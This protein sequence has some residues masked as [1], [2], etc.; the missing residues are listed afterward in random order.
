MPSINTNIAAL[1]AHQGLLR[2]NADLS[3]RL[4]RLSTGLRL[5]RAS[6][7]PAGQIKADRLGMELSGLRAAIDSAERGSALIGALDGQLAAIAD[8]LEALKALVGEQGDGA[9]LPP[10]DRQLAIDAELQ[11][12]E[13]IAN[14]AVFGG[15]RLLD[16]SL[17][18][19]L[20]FYDRAMV[21]RMEVHQADLAP[22][23][24]S[25]TLD[26]LVAAE[27]GLL[28]APLNAGSFIAG[29]LSEDVTLEISGPKGVRTLTFQAGATPVD[30]TTAINQLRD[31]TGVQ[32]S[33]V[34]PSGVASLEFRTIEYGSAQTVTVRAVSGTGAQWATR[35]QIGGV[36]V[37]SDNGV[38]VG[39]LVNGIAWVGRGRQVHFSSAAV[40]FTATLSEPFATNTATAAQTI[41]VLG[42]GVA[43]QVGPGSTSN[44]RVSFGVSAMI[45]SQMGRAM[46]VLRSEFVLSQLASGEPMSI[47]GGGD[48]TDAMRI[49][50]AAI[51]EV[52]TTRARLGAID[53]TRLQG[54]IESLQSAVESA[55]AGRSAIRDADVAEE[56]SALV[57]AQILSEASISMIGVAN[58][59]A[60]ALLRLLNR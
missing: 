1:I 34:N 36:A 17:D 56:T 45:P 4:E 2:A 7:D 24:L 18:Y 39:G 26:V 12:I 52:S 48:P 54:A 23:S 10:G 57:R 16:G 13:A 29:V 9:A 46:G 21:A 20:S 25:I 19:D 27:Q 14:S 58:Q 28:Y 22:G 35:A 3:V 8:R 44:D 15:R 42:G 53:R 60:E 31:Q 47:A 38:D 40:S 59:N 30:M 55:T 37:D 11:G 43:Y 41:Q 6:D 32:A 50:E 33:V 51:E 5:N 49:V